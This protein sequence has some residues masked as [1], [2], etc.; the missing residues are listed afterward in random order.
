MFD[1]GFENKIVNEASGI[2]LFP[3]SVKKNTLKKFVVEKL[4]F[5]KYEAASLIDDPTW[6][7]YDF[8]YISHRTSRPF[9][10]TNSFLKLFDK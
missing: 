5:D 3:A 2:V 10:V 9:A 8:L 1:G 4:S 7:Q 6:Y